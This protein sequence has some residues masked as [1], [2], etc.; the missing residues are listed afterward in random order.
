MYATGN[1]FQPCYST[2]QLKFAMENE[3]NAMTRV[4]D[5]KAVQ[6]LTLH[7][8][9][10]EQVFLA[11]T[12]ILAR[13]T[14][15]LYGRLDPHV[16]ILMQAP[17][18]AI[19]ES[20]RLATRFSLLAGCIALLAAVI[21]TFVYSLFFTRPI[22]AITLIAA[23]M[24][25][26]DFTQRVNVRTTDEIGELGHSVNTMADSLQHYMEQVKSANEQ[27]KKDIDEKILAEQTNKMLVS[28]V[29]HELKTPISIISGYAEGLKSGL[30]ADETTRDEY[31]NVILEESRNMNHMIQNLLRLTRLQS[32]QT[33]PRPVEVDL[34]EVTRK[35]LATLTLDLGAR[36]ISSQLDTVADAIVFADRDACEQVVRNYLFNAARYT[37]DQGLI[38]VSIQPR[39]G[40]LRFEVFNTGSHVAEEDSPHIWDSFYRSDVSRARDSGGVGLGLAIVRA[41]MTAHNSPFGYFN[42]ENG[43]VFFA[44]FRRFPEPPVV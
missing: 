7:L 43:V 29:S 37:N 30:A 5:T 22:R 13:D 39:N 18:E 2:K 24:A 11:E 41:H 25:D 6:S 16:T 15:S 44:E 3:R 34:A 8:G 36:E 28:N 17:L 12:E 33:T 21:I 23:H 14:L 40:N 19:T 38:R 20:A 4:Q 10:R 26:L 31:C 32:G 27:L 1:N 35:F 42:T 9:Q